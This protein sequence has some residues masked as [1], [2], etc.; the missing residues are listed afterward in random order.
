[1]FLAKTF[2][3]S[4]FLVLICPLLVIAEPLSLQLYEEN[5][6]KKCDKQIGQKEIAILSLACGRDNSIGSQIN[7]SNQISEYLFF[8]PI[9]DK[10]EQKLACLIDQTE[11]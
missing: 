4:I 7:D 9:A 5:R 10:E 11:S 2:S 8:K 1:M 6:G 3:S